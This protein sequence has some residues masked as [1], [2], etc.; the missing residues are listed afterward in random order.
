MKKDDTVYLKHMRDAIQRAERHLT[1]VAW[2]QFRQSE[3]VQDAVIRQLEI[4]GEATRNISE[5]FRRAH[6]YVPW[7][8]IIGLRN[9]LVHAYFAVDLTIVWE[10]VQIDLP[11]LKEQIERMLRNSSLD[12]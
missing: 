12:K 11:P 5:D 9:R 4:I 2:E 6:P 1:G 10:I 8:Q 7:S 3:I